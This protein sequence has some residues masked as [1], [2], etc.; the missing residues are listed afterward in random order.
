MIGSVIM[1]YIV[2]AVLLIVFAIFMGELFGYN[3]RIT[4]SVFAGFVI[5]L[6][7]IMAILLVFFPKKIPPD[8]K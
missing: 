3:T 1:W 5:F 4:F 6:A 7:M 2:I 8:T